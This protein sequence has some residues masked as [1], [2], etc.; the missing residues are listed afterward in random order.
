MYKKLFFVLIM[1][2]GDCVLLGMNE[3]KNDLQLCLQPF[4]F[5]CTNNIINEL[6]IQGLGRLGCA[7]KSWNNK[8]DYLIDDI[9]LETLLPI[10]AQLGILKKNAV[11]C[12]KA[13]CGYAEKL[14]SKE[15]NNYIKNDQMKRKIFEQLYLN[16][17]SIGYNLRSLMS[18]GWQNSIEWRDRMF[19]CAGCC[20][21]TDKTVFV[22]Q[23]KAYCFFKGAI[24]DKAFIL[25]ENIVRKNKL[26][27][28]R[29]INVDFDDF[30]G[31]DKGNLIVM[32]LLSFGLK[33]TDKCGRTALYVA[34]N[35]KKVNIVEL[36]LKESVSVDGRTLSL[37]CEKNDVD[38]IQ[39]F[40]EHGLSADSAINCSCCPTLLTHMDHNYDIYKDLLRTHV[41][42]YTKYRQYIVGATLL[43]PTICFL[44]DNQRS[45]AAVTI[46]LGWGGSTALLCKC[47]GILPGLKYVGVLFPAFMSFYSLWLDDF[48]ALLDDLCDAISIFA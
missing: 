22:Q 33:R 21:K 13:L 41:S 44:T 25:A 8:V 29:S 12:Q 42:F 47:F 18:C 16:D 27:Q 31:E 48:F 9:F 6:S 36:L 38:T 2:C 14:Y 4:N 34:Y 46:G 37:A 45:L 5:D 19:L 23:E 26:D 43:F 17:D 28:L 10:Y 30:V 35:H 11:I 1:L 7:N 20:E 24:A 32:F 3:K 15:E 40:L 39:L